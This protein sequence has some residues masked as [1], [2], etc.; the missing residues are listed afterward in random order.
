MIGGTVHGCS[1]HSVRRCTEQERLDCELRNPENPA[2]W[3]S[4]KD[5]RAYVD[6]VSEEP[7]EEEVE[8]PNFLVNLAQ[9]RWTLRSVD[10]APNEPLSRT[11]SWPTS[12]VGQPWC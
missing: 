6:V 12:S 4:L 9:T 2:E 1:V 11:S 5:M 7:D 10:T 8:L 3:K